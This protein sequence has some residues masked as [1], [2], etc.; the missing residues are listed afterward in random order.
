MN[1]KGPNNIVV[2]PQKGTVISPREG[3]LTR[4]RGYKITLDP[5]SSE[6]NGPQYIIVMEAYETAI[7]AGNKMKPTDISLAAQENLG[8][9]VEVVEGDA[10]LESDF[11]EAARLVK[12][13]GST[14]LLT[15]QG[16][17][18]TITVAHQLSSET[19]ATDMEVVSS[20]AK[21]TGPE[22]SGTQTI[23]VMEAVGVF[24]EKPAQISNSHDLELTQNPYLKKAA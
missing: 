24:H 1:E 17:K 6:F 11:R 14:I 16:I 12:K 8:D 19:I 23:N 9:Q 21:L 13:P 2:F 15:N 20:S 18:E 3:T 5:I 10:L 4:A 7:K 22:V